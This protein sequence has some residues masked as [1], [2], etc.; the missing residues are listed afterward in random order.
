MYDPFTDDQDRVWNMLLDLENED[1]IAE[2]AGEATE[3][4][5]DVYFFR[6]R[7]FDYI[8]RDV[9]NDLFSIAEA[10][11]DSCCEAKFSP[12]AEW[13]SYASL[14]NRFSSSDELDRLLFPW[15]EEIIQGILSDSYLM[16][17]VGFTEE[18]EQE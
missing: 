6:T 11:H 7:E 17:R 14:D 5:S 13:Q 10:V 3:H 2:I 9:N 15:K 1:E 16:E 4:G 18:Q 12:Y 8:M